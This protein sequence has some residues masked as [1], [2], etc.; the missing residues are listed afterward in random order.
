[1]LIAAQLHS[2]IEIHE[3]QA[4]FAINAQKDHKDLMQSLA[5][6]IENLQDGL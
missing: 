3:W 1:M 6:G 4:Q 5:G 2:H